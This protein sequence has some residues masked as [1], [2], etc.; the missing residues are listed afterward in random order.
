MKT[1]KSKNLDQKL[2]RYSALILAIGGL[3]EVNAQIVYT[4]IDPDETGSFNSYYFFD[5]DNNGTID[6]NLVN[7]VS[8][9]YTSYY[10]DPIINSNNLLLYTITNSVL[11]SSS[12]I[13]SMALALDS[14]AVISSGQNQWGGSVL[15]MDYGSGCFTGDIWCDVTDKY[16]GLRFKIDGND[17]YGWARLDVGN[18]PHQYTLKDYAY[19]SV[20]GQ[21]ILAGQTVL[22]IEGHIPISSVKVVNSVNKTIL[23]SNLTARVDFIVYSIAGKKILDGFLNNSE[24]EI[25]LS[26]F[27]N[28]IYI[29][30]L[31]DYNTGN[32]YLKKIVI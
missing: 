18:A 20:A 22:S 21:A 24:N 32:S 19:N 1:N 16:L 29:L 9:Y 5:I 7:N 23:L 4:D 8:L 25:D 11:M 27:S 3:T 12:G 10:P 17:H 15:A 28:G 26:A 6:F 31:I 30:E 14:G 13:T 2:S